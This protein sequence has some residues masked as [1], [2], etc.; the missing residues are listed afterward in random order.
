MSEVALPAN[1]NVMSY[2]F[3]KE[4]S[5]V[6]KCIFSY[7]TTVAILARSTTAI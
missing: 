6:V 3:R 1:D 7:L 5:S 4:L 2:G